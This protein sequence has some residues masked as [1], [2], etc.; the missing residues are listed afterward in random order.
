MTA[1]H[2]GDSPKDHGDPLA[3]EAAGTDH[4]VSPP[5]EEARRVLRARAADTYAPPRPPA[6]SACRTSG[7]ASSS[8]RASSPANVTPPACSAYRRRLCTPS[9]PVSAPPRDLPSAPE[10]NRPPLRPTPR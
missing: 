7:Y 8:P 6:C 5:T 3:A 9:A 10:G 2:D 4:V 1:D